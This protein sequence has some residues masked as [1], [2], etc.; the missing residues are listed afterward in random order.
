MTAWLLLRGGGFLSTEDT[1]GTED[2]EPDDNLDEVFNTQ[3][4]AESGALATEMERSGMVKST[5]GT[6]SLTAT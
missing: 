4:E 1:E 6:E 3:P 5:E 2:T